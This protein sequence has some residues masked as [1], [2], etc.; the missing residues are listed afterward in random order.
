MALLK[1]MEAITIMAEHD[2]EMNLAALYAWIRS[3]KC[4]FG[5]YSQAG[6]MSERGGYTIFRA[7]L[8]YWLQCKDMNLNYN[9]GPMNPLVGVGKGGGL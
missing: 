7:R 1:P 8:L 3:G 4:P 9:N 5:A 6:E 2:C